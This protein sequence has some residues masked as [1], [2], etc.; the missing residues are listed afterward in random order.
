MG[1]EHSAISHIPFKNPVRSLSLDTAEKLYPHIIKLDLANESQCR[2]ISQLIHTILAEHTPQLTT[3]LPLYIAA[4]ASQQTTMMQLYATQLALTKTIFYHLFTATA[5]FISKI[6]ALKSKTKTQSKTLKNI[7]AVHSY[8]ALKLACLYEQKINPESSDDLTAVVQQGIISL[9]KQS[10]PEPWIDQLL[11]HFNNKINKTKPSF[12]MRTHESIIQFLDYVGDILHS[13]T[14]REQFD[15]NQ[16]TELKAILDTAVKSTLDSINNEIRSDIKTALNKDI[17]KFYLCILQRILETYANLTTQDLAK[18]NFES[19]TKAFNL[20]Q[21]VTVALNGLKRKLPIKDPFRETINHHIQKFFTQKTQFNRLLKKEITARKIAA[22]QLVQQEKIKQ[23]RA[24]KI[25]DNKLQQEL[26]KKRQHNQKIAKLKQSLATVA[27][28]NN[29]AHVQSQSSPEKAEETLA[30]SQA[31]E[32]YRQ[33]DWQTLEHAAKQH[34][35]S[36]SA[37]K[38]FVSK[39]RFLLAESYA[40]K[41]AELVTAN[42]QLVAQLQSSF[43]YF[44]C[45][46]NN[47]ISCNDKVFIDFESVSTLFNKFK[48]G[49][50]DSQLAEYYFHDIIKHDREFLSS[51]SHFFI[52]NTLDLLHENY[53]KISSTLELIHNW[54]QIR[55][56][57]L[58]KLGVYGQGNKKQPSQYTRLTDSVSSFLAAHHIASV[59]QLPEEKILSTYTD[60]KASAVPNDLVADTLNELAHQIATNAD[61]SQQAADTS[62]I[63]QQAILKATHKQVL[64]ALPD[65]IRQLLNKLNEQ[66]INAW[67]VGGAILNLMRAQNPKDYD[68]RIAGISRIE[69]IKILQSLSVPG[70]KLFVCHHKSGLFQLKHHDVIIDFYL[71]DETNTK[72]IDPLDNKKYFDFSGK[73]LAMNLHEL[74]DC[75]A[76]QTAISDIKQGYLRLAGDWEDETQFFIAAPER[77]F[78]TIRHIGSWAITPSLLH[79]ID[80]SKDELTNMY[81][82]Q[83]TAFIAYLTKTLWYCRNQQAIDL[84]ILYVLPHIIP[85]I[86]ELNSMQRQ[87]LSSFLIN[88]VN[89]RPTEY[90]PSK[91]IAH[92][93][94]VIKVIESMPQ[95]YQN[96]QQLFELYHSEYQKAEQI[97]LAHTHYQFTTCRHITF[98]TN[99]HAEP[100]PTSCV[101]TNSP[102]NTSNNSTPKAILAN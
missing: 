81:H 50:K 59:K 93:I 44:E 100:M 96:L 12:P 61:S 95:S 80:A 63:M 51:S 32:F 22:N 79:A 87:H 78:R 39:N 47:Q 9:K 66:N 10:N 58:K 68:F 42:E 65:F 53:R 62:P 6:E 24:Q 85:S 64:T 56:L 91:S 16:I 7:L 41:V 5:L 88:A 37:S 1:I 89:S 18:D 97:E 90:S 27:L 70:E 75:S 17:A 15:L 94:S 82:N 98:S 84:L 3:N 73:A 86:T 25:Y 21:S 45:T 55:K 43:K 13:T 33:R 102:T 38:T 60:S 4:K 23:R 67:L 77:I 54:L 26:Q 2:R 99:A 40:T 35:A 46:L 20:G 74:R 71:L 36:K 19:T 30:F 76:T 52:Q 28:L 14:W 48:I 92:R 49:L 69:L 8:L 34:I 57:Y 31:V 11:H 29:Q 101:V 72:T 83:R